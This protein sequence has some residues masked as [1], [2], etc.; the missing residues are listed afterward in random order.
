M[1][2]AWDKRKTKP[3]TEERSIQEAVKLVVDII[4]AVLM[5]GIQE[6]EWEQKAKKFGKYVRPVCD[7]M[8]ALD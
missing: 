1:Q 2:W 8:D 6:E 7:M 5:G 4:S 3:G